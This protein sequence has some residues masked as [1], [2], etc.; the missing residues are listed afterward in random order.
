MCGLSQI[1]VSFG[2]DESRTGV[3]GRLNASGWAVSQVFHRA[4]GRSA[5][6]L[7]HS[8]FAIHGKR[9]AL[10]CHVGAESLGGDGII[11]AA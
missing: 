3:S 9:R 5:A 2:H 8:G 4:D 1:R 7:V 11:T 6:D 10:L